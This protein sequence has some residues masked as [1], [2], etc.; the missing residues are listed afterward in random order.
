M[1]WWVCPEHP[2]VYYVGWHPETCM[3]P[4]SSYCSKCGVV[5]PPIAHVLG[6]D[7]HEGR[8]G[9]FIDYEPCSLRLEYRQEVLV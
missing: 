7:V 5:K 8:C 6:V 1:G 4:V 3:R 2:G 9:G